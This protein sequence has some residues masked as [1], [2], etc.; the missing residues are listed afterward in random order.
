[1]ETFFICKTCGV[2]LEGRKKLF[3][4]NW[5]K[6]KI[7]SPQTAID[8]LHD[9][10]QPKCGCGCEQE[11]KYFP[12][13]GDYGKFFAGHISRIKNNF[14][15]E[16]SQ[17]NS[18]TTRK[19]LSEQGLLKNSE[20]TKKKKSFARMGSKNPM[21]HKTHSNNTKE[22]IGELT[23]LKWTD[24]Q[25]REKMVEGAK[26][27]WTPEHRHDQGVKRALYMQSHP[28][29]WKPS[30]LEDKFAICLDEWGIKYK[31]QQRINNKVFDFQLENTKIIIEVDGN[32]WHCNPKFFPEGPKFQCQVDAIMNDAT[33]NLLLKEA[34]YKLVRLWEDDINNNL[35]EVK[36][37]ILKEI[38][39]TN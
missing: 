2:Q 19:K 27:F 38:N 32:F 1:M 31:R 11:T 4:H 7:K 35:E 14:N 23:K 25:I 8:Y 16:K 39:E 18:A 20:E 15:T 26:K 3:M 6:H 17:T 37:R 33:K 24:P 12:S 30:K 28:Y 21:F 36:Q 9:G 22:K 10:V 5:K 34:G 29:Q 13:L